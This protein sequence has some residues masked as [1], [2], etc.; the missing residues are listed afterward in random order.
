MNSMRCEV[1]LNQEIN[2]NWKRRRRVLLVVDYLITSCFRSRAA[3]PLSLPAN[4]LLCSR[5]VSFE[6][7]LP[8][9]FGQWAFV[10]CNRTRPRINHRA[11]SG[12]WSKLT[13]CLPASILV[14]RPLN[15]LGWR[16]DNAFNLIGAEFVCGHNCCRRHRR[17]LTKKFSGRRGTEIFVRPCSRVR[18]QSNCQFGCW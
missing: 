18:Q 7:N 10:V 13:G 14:G 15:P 4:S 17:R 16:S 6:T 12:A 8:R 5:L 3:L 11:P 1:H 2:H 9:R